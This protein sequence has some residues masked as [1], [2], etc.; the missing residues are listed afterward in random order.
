MSAVHAATPPLPLRDGIPTLAPLLEMIT[1]A[2]VNISVA[3]MAPQRHNPLF[4]D[5]FFRRFF[6]LPDNAPARPQQSAG[7]GVIVDAARGL[8][9]SITTSSPGPTR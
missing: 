8:V 3:T 4:R 2:V 9:L 7:S 6:D 5:P 1:P